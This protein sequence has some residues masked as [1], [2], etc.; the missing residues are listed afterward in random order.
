MYWWCFDNGN[1]WSTCLLL[2]VPFDAIYSRNLVHRD[3]RHGIWTLTFTALYHR[4]W[5]IRGGRYK[6]QCCN[7]SNFLA[8]STKVAQSRFFFCAEENIGIGHMY[9]WHTALQEEH[10]HLSD[11]T[12]KKWFGSFLLLL[13]Q[14]NIIIPKVFLCLYFVLNLVWLN[15]LRMMVVEKVPKKILYCTLFFNGPSGHRLTFRKKIV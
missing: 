5:T 11:M 15:W 9:M 13:W 12:V 1:L 2:V 3:H 14:E 6:Q 8:L 7:D 4:N 10:L